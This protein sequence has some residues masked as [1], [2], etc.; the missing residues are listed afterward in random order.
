MNECCASFFGGSCVIGIHAEQDDLQVWI[1]FLKQA[2][3]FGCGGTVES[4][5][6]QKQIRRCIG[7]RADQ[8]LHILNFNNGASAQFALQQK[9]KRLAGRGNGG[10]AG[11]SARSYRAGLA[12]TKTAGDG[13]HHR[14]NEDLPSGGRRWRSFRPTDSRR[15]RIPG[16]TVCA[17]SRH[18][19]SVNK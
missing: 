9:S 8:S 14:G 12:V 1:S 18:R 15:D 5:I 17:A 19:S 13:A 4:P 6:Q 11:G 16:S 2:A 10:K 3:G 7:K